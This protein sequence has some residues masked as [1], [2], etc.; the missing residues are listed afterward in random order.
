MSS[1]G[2]HLAPWLTHQFRVLEIL[3]ESMIVGIQKARTTGPRQ[4][5]HVRAVRDALSLDAGRLML[6]VV[7]RNQERATS[8]AEC[9]DSPTDSPHAQQFTRE[10]AA[11]NE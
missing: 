2:V 4:R 9:L 3:L 5:N 7:G 1:R 6:H 8:L 11:V 10:L